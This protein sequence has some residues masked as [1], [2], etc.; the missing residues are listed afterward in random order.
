MPLPPTRIYSNCMFPRLTLHVW[1]ALART[2]SLSYCGSA[3]HWKRRKWSREEGQGINRREDRKRGQ[4][5]TICTN[6]LFL[7]VSCHHV[8]SR[9]GFVFCGRETMSRLARYRPG[10]HP[11]FPYMHV[12]CITF[13]SLFIWCACAF[14]NLPN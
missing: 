7:D 14:L 11:G 5:T 3:L 10:A 12:L 6:T 2:I 1:C 13:A 8:V 4:E 9:I